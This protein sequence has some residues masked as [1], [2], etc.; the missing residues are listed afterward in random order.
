[1]LR[2]V[3]L[4]VV[5]PIMLGSGFAV[6]ADDPPGSRRLACERVPKARFALEWPVRDYLQKV[7]KHWLMQ[8]PEANP[9]MLAMFRDRDRK[10]YRDLL[11][12]S[13]EFAGK[14]LTG[15]TQVLRV[16]GDPELKRYL[17]AFVEQL[18]ALQDADGYL[19]PFPRGHRL[20]GAF[21]QRRR[22]GRTNMGR[23]GALPCHARSAAL[24]RAGGRPRRPCRRGAD[25]RPVLRPV[26]GR[27]EASAGGYRLDRDEPG[28]GPFA[29]PA[30]STHGH[31][32]VPRSGPADRRRVRRPGRQR[33][34]DGGRLSPRRP[35]RDSV[36]QDAQATLGEPAP[37]HGP[38]RTL[39]DHRR[40]AVPIGVRKPVVE[41]RRPR[42]AQQRRVLF[43]R[44]G[45]GQPLSSRRDRDLLHDRLDGDERR[46]VGD[47]RQFDRR[48]RV[49]TLD[50]EFRD[51]DV[52]TDRPMEHVQHAD[53]R[54]SQ[55]E[56]P[57]D[58]LPV[59]ARLARAELLQRERGA[60]ARPHRRMGRDARSG[61]PLTQLVWGRIDH[62]GSGSRGHG[63]ARAGDRLSA[64]R[65]SSHPGRAE[66]EGVVHATPPN[67]ALVGSYR[68][69]GQ[70]PTR[71]G[72]DSGDVSVVVA[73][74][75]SGR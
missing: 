74:V 40:G 39:P 42:P 11:P 24:G 51:R 49:G 57:R 67:P 29:L 10:P 33:Q 20:T 75:G 5:L 21:A 68:G 4:G 52:L 12:W 43:G 27:Q 63:E 58:Q 62:R 9:A 13:G 64:I 41:H 15:G 50:A 73:S 26:P 69:E 22:E 56:F 30:S 7:T 6:A 25:R 66:T 3:A 72:R 60:G 36:L 55:G 65:T 14:Y 59:P 47:H 8:A 54:R 23:M 28:P 34:A 44:A 70:R 48:R 16:A 17:S 32:A 37:D 71:I 18:A 38:C 31:P 35:G 61:R 53:G 19:G 45:S 2:A 46:N 1:M